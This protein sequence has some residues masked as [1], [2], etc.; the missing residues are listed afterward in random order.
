MDAAPSGMHQNQAPPAGASPAPRGGR[1]PDS[2]AGILGAPLRLRLTPPP[3]GP[4][5]EGEPFGAR[6]GRR[7][8]TARASDS[9][10]GDRAGQGEGCLEPSRSWLWGP[11]KRRVVFSWDFFSHTTKTPSAQPVRAWRLGFFHPLL[12]PAAA[13]LLGLKSRLQGFQT[14][15]RRPPAPGSLTGLPQDS[16]AWRPG[17]CLVLQG[18]A[19]FPGCAVSEGAAWSASPDS[20]PY[21]STRAP[22]RLWP[23]VIS[24][25]A[26]S[27][28]CVAQSRVCG[29]GPRSTPRP[30]DAL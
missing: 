13:V 19:H 2:L 15:L 18:A 20:S 30:S 25:G 24:E 1:G 23:T 7:E 16:G 22:L 17:R 27:S 9:R 5:Q 4:R 11:A 28:P 6:R 26:T 12:S 14:S 21:R 29:K 10:G 8:P 3:A